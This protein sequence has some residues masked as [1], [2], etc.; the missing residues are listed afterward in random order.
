MGVA[1]THSRWVNGALVFYD[2]ND[3]RKAWLDAMG[4]NVV[5]YINDFTVCPRSTKAA[6]ATNNPE[7]I[8][9]HTSAGTGHSE[10]KSADLTGGVMTLEPATNDNDGI[11]MQLRGEDFSPKTDC[12]L[13]FGV[14]YKCDENTQSDFII[15]IVEHDTVTID[16]SSH[17]I[18]FAT[19]DGG[20]YV[21]LHVV[22]DGTTD[23]T[24][25]MTTGLTNT[26]W[27]VDEF[28]V[29][30]TSKVECWHNNSYIGSVTAGIPSTDM[31][32][33]VAFEAG[34]ANSTYNLYVDWIRCIQLNN[35]R[36]TE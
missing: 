25:N 3:H 30:S 35:A 23:K 6:D 28:L 14:R 12:P 4:T 26:G 9:T 24:T 33:T 22:K 32:V 17:G 7:W 20:T 10:V 11:N 34:A 27:N 8:I 5:K 36:T 21:K 13:Y 15:G 18:F 31:A 1:N 16:G 19:T 29:S 2:G